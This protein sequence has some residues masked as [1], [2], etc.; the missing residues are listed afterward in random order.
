MLGKNKNRSEYALGL[1]R[2]RRSRVSTAAVS[3]VGLAAAV[4]AGVLAWGGEYAMAALGLAAAAAVGLAALLVKNVKEA[5][6]VD[7]IRET[8]TYAVKLTDAWQDKVRAFQLRR[9]RQFYMTVFLVLSTVEAVVLTVLFLVT[10]SSVYLL[11]LAA[12]AL[13]CL[14]IAFAAGLYLG[15]RLADRC[16]YIT[17]SPHGAVVCGDVVTFSVEKEDVQT[18]YAFDDAYLVRLRR[19]GL[20]GFVYNSELL[21]PAGGAVRKG[22]DMTADEAV[23]AA[24]GVDAL[25]EVEGDFYENRSYNDPVEEEPPAEVP[26]EEVSAEAPVTEDAAEET[27]AADVPAEQTTKSPAA[28]ETAVTE[29]A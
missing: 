25:T 13:I 1:V 3:A 23:C 18:V 22:L 11:Y 26:A 10:G 15:V 9:G 4:A 16:A 24:L 27:P 28:E 8:G 29:L 21:L 7:R 14:F 19:E 6:A 2:A 17:V 5:K 12:F 20:F